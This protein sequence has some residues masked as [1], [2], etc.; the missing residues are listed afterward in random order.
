ML[1]YVR[2]LSVSGWTPEQKQF[3]LAEREISNTL[4]KH[5]HQLLEPTKVDPTAASELK[6]LADSKW[7]WARLYVAEI[8]KHHPG[9]RNEDVIE[10]LKK[11]EN[12]LVRETVDFNRKPAAGDIPPTAPQPWGMKSSVVP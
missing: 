12:G 4:W 8:M 3:L 9:F 2:T 1:G 6:K 11:D 7:W 10:K 5:D